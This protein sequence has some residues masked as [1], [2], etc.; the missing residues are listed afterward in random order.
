MSKP[1]A[2]GRFCGCRLPAAG[3]G[4]AVLVQGVNKMRLPD[5]WI[6]SY[7]MGC[8]VWNECVREHGQAAMDEMIA[9]AMAAAPPLCWWCGAARGVG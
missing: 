7:M 9:W 6:E 2:D 4:A 8:F 5:R 3:V 1:V